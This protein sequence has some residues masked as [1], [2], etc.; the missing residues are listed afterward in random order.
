M[1]LTSKRLCWKGL[2][3]RAD[4][5]KAVLSAEKETTLQ[6]VKS[7]VAKAK[8]LKRAADE[9][10]GQLDNDLTR[11]KAL[12]RKNKHRSDIE[13]FTLILCWYSSFMFWSVIS[14]LCFW[15]MQKYTYVWVGFIVFFVWAETILTF[16]DIHLFLK[17]LFCGL[18]KHCFALLCSL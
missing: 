15:K 4:A 14:R 16:F 6:D 13:W 17:F 8:F 11:K 2:Q 5:D 18:I 7:A 3:L 10:Q 12:M 1:K 9:K